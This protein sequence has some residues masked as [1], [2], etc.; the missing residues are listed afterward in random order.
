MNTGQV[1]TGGA[2]FAQPASSYQARGGTG[3]RAYFASDSR[4][5]IQSVLGL[6]WLLVGG[7]QFQSFMY[8]NGFPQMLTGME[9]GQPH[10]VASSVGWGARL[11]NGNLDVWNTLFALTQIL[12]GLGLLYRP[13]VKLALGASFLWVLNVW[14]FGEAFGML[15]ANT[16]N[17]LTGAP[18]AVLIYALIGL[19]V[20]PNGRRGGLLGERGARLAW[21]ILW[22]VMG[23]LWLLGANNSANATHDA[24]SAAPSGMGWLS[25]LESNAARI[26]EGNGFL[27]ALILAVVSVV[28]GVAVGAN[29]E[30]RTFLWLAI[31]LNA[32]YWVVGQGFGG[33]ATG[34]AT[35]PN[36]GLP[37]IV[38]ACAL[39]TAL[40][41]Q[42][43]GQSRHGDA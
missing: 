7:L 23:W 11:A 17:P 41:S 25:S 16:A 13:T 1:S 40:P 19:I 15:F 14:W 4:R 12:L 8:S 6:M 34:S 32:I 43:G 21:A 26:T 24:I 2:S 20:W 22:V 35:D 10:W 30:P 39:F 33:L 5:T 38:L 9:P 3:V 37:F 18:G 36:A 28:I 27:I 29:W 31:Y 42:T